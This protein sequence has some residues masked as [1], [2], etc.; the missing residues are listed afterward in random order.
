MGCIYRPKKSPYLWIKYYQHGEAQYESTKTDKVKVA[1]KILKDR[2]GRVAT[3]QPILPRADKVKYEDAAEDLKTHYRTTGCRNLKEAE[4]RFVPLLGFFCGYRLANIGPADITKYVARRQSQEVSNGTI[5]RELAVLGK[6]FR[7]AVENNK[8]LRVPVIRKLKENAPRQGFFERDAYAAVRKHLRPDLQCAVAIEYELG[9]RCQSEVL[10]L[11]LRQIDLKASTI[12]L[13]A[14]T[15]KNYEGRVVYLPEGLKSEIT[16]QIERVRKLERK[17]GRVIPYLFPHF[18]NGR[19]YC[20]GERLEDFK[21]AWASAC[22]KA[23]FYREL[24]REKT[25]AKGKT[26]TVTVRVPT[27]LRH[28]FRRTAVRNLV[29]AGVPER[30][31]MSVTGHRTRS[32]FDRYHIVSPAD[33]QEAARKL[34]AASVQ[35][36]RESSN[37]VPLGAEGSR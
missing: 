5:N 26:Q 35:T 7:L 1:E 29:N 24:K 19:R 37:V 30:V 32:V 22:V 4:T 18:T 31:A 15:T 9:W 2:E 8:L 34:E 6:L 10:T 13:D 33:L 28:D 36:P 3:G 25:N 16:A 21:K 23:G 14:G 17:L 27:M 20:Q 11:E 12:R